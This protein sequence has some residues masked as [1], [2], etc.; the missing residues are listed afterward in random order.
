MTEP[1]EA[2]PVKRGYGRADKVRAA[3]KQVGSIASEPA[4]KKT[5]QDS[6]AVELKKDSPYSRLAALEKDKT[7]ESPD[8]APPKEKESAAEMA[9]GP[10]K[11]K[12]SPFSQFAA[13]A[14]SAESKKSV[15][16]APPEMLAPSVAIEND[17]PLSDQTPEDNDPGEGANSASSSPAPIQAPGPAADVPGAVSTVVTPKT[18]ESKK[19][20]FSRFVK[21]PPPPARQS[22][23]VSESMH[24]YRDKFAGVMSSVGH[25]SVEENL[26]IA[27]DLSS[28]APINVDWP[29]LNKPDGASGWNDPHRPAG[30]LYSGE[31]W[32]AASEG[33]KYVVIEVHNLGESGLVRVLAPPALPPEPKTKHPNWKPPPAPE[34]QPGMLDHMTASFFDRCLLLQEGAQNEY[35]HE[36]SSRVFVEWPLGVVQYDLVRSQTSIEK[37]A[38]VLGFLGSVWKQTSTVEQLTQ[39]AFDLFLRPL[40]PD[41][42]PVESDSAGT[43]PRP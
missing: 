28:S 34:L 16:S 8:T 13:K 7:T 22:G 25:N 17:A 14:K 9:G 18:G 19:S 40:I 10:V 31:E 21:A 15:P 36:V 2:K 43:S 3:L 4:G 27:A 42:E 23:S 20:A 29:Y 35:P 26:K 33:G 11:R 12:A 30:S 41:P 39:Q 37:N 38:G 32:T 5:D 24:A 6:S 1:T